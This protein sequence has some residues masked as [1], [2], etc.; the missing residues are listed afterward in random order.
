[1]QKVVVMI[2]LSW[3]YTF[4][5]DH[6]LLVN[7]AMSTIYY[8]TIIKIGI[9]FRIW[10]TYLR[11]FFSPFWLVSFSW[12]NHIITGRTLTI[13]K[14]V[15]CCFWG[16]RWG[17][18]CI[19]GISVHFK[20]KLYLKAAL[21]R[22]RGSGERVTDSERNC[23]KVAYEVALTVLCQCQAGAAPQEEVTSVSL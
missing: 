5:F 6:T 7:Y 21:Y 4:D 1:M 18:V 12:I 8:L 23:S 10:A 14:N 9:H 13:Y 2:I 22:D 3:K 16:G 20:L 19:N 17:L 15:C 11:V